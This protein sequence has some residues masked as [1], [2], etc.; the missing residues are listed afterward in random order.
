M[1]NTQISGNF[2]LSEVSLGA[3][4]KIIIKGYEVFVDRLTHEINAGVDKMNG[5]VDDLAL[6]VKKGFDEVDEQF[7]EVRLDF[8]EVNGRLSNLEEGQINLSEKLE[9]TNQR[10]DSVHRTVINDHGRRI[11]RVETKLQIA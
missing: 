5:K 10:L 8:K 11:H 2:N 7:R 9:E 4:E 6:A 3:I 1:S